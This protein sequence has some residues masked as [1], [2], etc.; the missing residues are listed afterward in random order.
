MDIKIISCEDGWMAEMEGKKYVG[1][2]FSH[3][4]DKLNKIIKSTI[5]KNKEVGV[6]VGIKK[7]SDTQ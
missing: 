2:T 5:G 4:C 6:K 1:L 7:V 3:L